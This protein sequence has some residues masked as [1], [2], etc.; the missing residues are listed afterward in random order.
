ARGERLRP[1]FHASSDA[2]AFGL[3]HVGAADA[4]GRCGASAHRTHP[5][6][7]GRQHHARGNHPRHRPAYLAAEAA[8]LRHRRGR[9]TRAS[10]VFALA[11]AACG[12]GTRVIAPSEPEDE[13]PP[14]HAVALRFEEATPSPDGTPRTRVSLVR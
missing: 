14:R 1:A 4:F 3:D 7:D 12:G 11:L 13:A 10:L 9:M 2:A 8:L 5:G 6:K